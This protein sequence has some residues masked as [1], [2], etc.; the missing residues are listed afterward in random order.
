[1]IA[2][3]ILFLIRRRLN[4]WIDRKFFREHYNQEN[5]LRGLIE[6]VRKYDSIPY[7][8]RLVSRK[9]ESALHPERIYLFYREEDSRDLSLGYSSG[10]ASEELRIPEEFRLLRLM[11]G[12]ARAD[13][14]PFP[15]KNNLP[16]A[17]EE[18]LAALG[19]RLIV[20]LVGTDRLAGLFLLG[21][22]K[23]EVP[24]TARDRNLLESVAGQVALVY[25]NAQLKERVD[26][27]RKIK[28]E[29]V[30]CFEER[31]INLLKECTR[32]GAC[33]DTSAMTCDKDG[34]ELT[35]SMPV[36]RTVDGRYRLER[37]VGR[38]GMG[39]DS[40]ATVLRLNRR[41]T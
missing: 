1:M 18:W 20:P 2:A 12:Q 6:D 15:Q 3:A 26:R 11:E 40:E 34:S 7:M 31:H 25:E 14:V 17:E 38:G 9:V 32:C 35:L 10:G 37:L 13:D 19:T 23:S 22:K 28:H 36:E 41:D 27:E 16:S 33:F 4:D 29:W 39:A 21:E 24:Y 8:S 5:I 30:G